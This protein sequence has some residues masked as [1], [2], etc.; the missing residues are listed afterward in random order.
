M[1]LRIKKEFFTDCT[2]S[3]LFTIKSLAE[4]IQP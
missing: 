3:I 2:E 4:K 1:Q